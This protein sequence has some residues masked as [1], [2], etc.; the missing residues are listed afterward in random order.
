MRRVADAG[1]RSVLESADDGSCGVQAAATASPK[2]HGLLRG[3]VQRVE[4]ASTTIMVY[5]V[6]HEGT[7]L[8]ESTIEVRLPDGGIRHERVDENGRWRADDIESAGTDRVRMRR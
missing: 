4:S 1:E 2:S 6:N 7:P 5:V 8:P 3:A